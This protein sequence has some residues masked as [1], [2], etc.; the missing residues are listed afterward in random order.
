[1]NRIYTSIWNEIT[2][3]FVAAAECVRRKGKSSRSSRDGTNPKSA[4]AGRHVRRL[5]MPLALEQRFMF[6]GAAVVD[7]VH[8]I[9]D[10][11]APL[12]EAPAAVATEKHAIAF[13]DTAVKDYQALVNGLDPAVE[14]VLISD[15]DGVKQMADA[16]SG[17]TNLDAI[18][19]ISHGSEG[20]VDIGATTLNAGNLTQYADDL[21]RIGASLSDQGDLVLYGCDV[22]AGETGRQLVNDLALATGADVA[23]SGDKTGNAALGGDW[24]LEIQSG[25]IEANLPFSEAALNDF[26]SLLVGAPYNLEIESAT[27]WVAGNI[28][29]TV[30]GHTLIIDG[31]QNLGLATNGATNDYFSTAG[32]AGAPVET[33]I[34]FSFSN[35]ETFNAVSIGTIY[36]DS[37]FT[38][39]ISDNLGNSYVQSLT[40][41][42]IAPTLNWNG[43]TKLYFENNAGGVFSLQEVDN[44]NF[45]NVTAPANTAPTVTTPTAITLTDTAAADSF[46][47]T[48][49]TLSATDSDVIASYGISTGTTSG[50][51]VIGGVTYDVS[52]AGSYGTLYVK[53]GTGDYA[54]VPNASAV[55]ARTTNTSE[56]FTVTATD[57]NASPATGN[58]TLTINVT[59]ANDVPTLTTASNITGGTEDTQKQIT[60]A[61]LQTAGNEADVDGSVSAFVVKAVSSGTLLIGANAGAATP[62]DA[63]T[64]ATIDATHLAFWTPAS[65]ANGN[66]NAFTVV[67]KDD[68]GSESTTPVQVVVEIAVAND[69]PTLSGVPGSA[70][71]VTT[72][73]AAAL[74]NF[75][76]AD[77][78]GDSLTV[79]LTPTNG[80]IGGLTGWTDT[81]GVLSK[82]DTAANLNTDLAG[83]TFTATNAGAASIGVSVDDGTAAPVTGTYS[84]T[85]STPVDA[86][87]D[88]NA[89]SVA[90]A[91]VGST[92]MLDASPNATL[93]HADTSAT[94]WNGATLTA[95]R[96]GTAITTDTFAF[97]TTGASFTA[98]GG[99]L[100][101]GGQTF[102]TYTS[103][104]G[105]LTINFA[106]GGTDATNAL[107]D[108]VVQRIT[109]RNDTPA[110]NATVR[111]TLTPA[112]ASAVTADVTVTTDK[113]YVTTGTDT[114]TDNL[115]DGVSFSEALR[116]A[117]NQ[118]GTDTLVLKSTLAN[119][120]VS[121]TNVASLSGDVIVDGD[122]ASGATISNGSL[123][124]N[125][126]TLAFTNGSGDTLSV[127][128]NL[129]GTGSLAKTGAGT[130]TL[131]GTNTYSGTT[132]VTGGKVTANGSGSLG[133]SAVTLDGGAL[134]FGAT[135]SWTIA[136]NITLGAGGGTLVSS[137][138]SNGGTTT[139]SGV[140]SG[141]N[142]T[143]TSGDMANTNPQNGI[144]YLTGSNTYTGTT[145]L[146]LNN[147][148]GTAKING[149]ANLGSGNIIFTSGKLSITG[150]TT[151]DNAIQ[152]SGTNASFT[153]A[154]GTTTEIT[155]VISGNNG[156]TTSG[157]GGTLKLSGTNTYSGSTY[158]GNTLIASSDAALPDGTLLELGAGTLTLL[159]NQT[160]GALNSYA[161]LSY[162]GN[163]SVI[164]LGTY[165]FTLAGG[166]NSN[167]SGTINGSGN[168]VKNGGG[169][170]TIS[171]TTATANSGDY[172]GTTTI[173]AGALQLDGTLRGP[174]TVASGGKLSGGGAD[175]TQGKALGSVTVQSGGT[176][177]PG[178]SGGTNSTADLTTGNLTVASGGTLA[179]TVGG[180]TAGATSSG[181]D[182]VAVTGTVDITG[183]TLSVNVVGGF[184]PVAGDVFT[185]VANDSN[186]AI[187]GTFNGLAEGATV[188]VSGTPFKLSYVGGTDGNDITLTVQMVFSNVDIS[189]D[190]GITTDFITGTAAQTITA[191]LSAN[192]A[193]GMTIKGSVDGG[194]N[195]TDVTNKV[196]GMSLSWDGATLAEGVNAIKFKALNASSVNVGEISQA[197]TLDTS[198]PTTAIATYDIS[199][200]TGDA[201][202]FITKTASQTVS[203]TLGAVTVAGETVQVSAD[204]GATWAD[205]T[206]VIGENTWSLSGVTLQAG[207]NDLKVRVVDEAGNA[208]SVTTQSYTLDTT[209]PTITVSAIGISADTG[210]SA[211][212]FKTKTASQTITATLSGAPAGT[213]KVWGSVDNGANWI[214]VTSMVSGTTL[215][216]T[217][218]TLSGSST[219]K[220]KVSDEAGN[221]G[222][223]ASQA[224]V[225][226]TAAP[227]ASVTTANVGIGSNVAT[228]QSTE[229]GLIYLVPSGQTPADYAALE[230]LVTGGTATK[231]TVTTGGSN[232]PI[233]TTGLTS[234]TYKVWAVDAAGNIS[235]AS[236]NTIT[237]GTPPTTTVAT[238]ALSADTGASSTDFITNTASQTISGTL[239]AVTVA[240]EAIQVSLDNG[241]TWTNATNTT[242][243]NTW[244]LAGQTLSGS[245]ILQARVVNAGGFGSTPYTHNYTLDTTAPTTTIA[246]KS[247]SND[248]GTSS[249]DFITN[250][251]NQTISGTLSTNLAAGEIVQVSLDN[252]STWA[253][254]TATT[255]QNT[256]SLAGQTLTGS[257]TLKVRVADAAGNGGTAASQAYVLDTTAPATTVATLA[258]S[259]D[260][261]TSSTDFITSTASQ[262]ISGTLSNNLAADEIVQVSLDNGSTWTTATASTGQNTW[263]LAGQTLT[264]SDTL[265]VRVADAA[266][267][268]GSVV[269]QAYVLDT[270]VAAPTVGLTSDTGS[271]NSDK[272]TSNGALSVGGT[273][274][275]ATVQYSTDSTNWSGSFTPVNGS[276]TVYVRQTDAAGNVSNASSAYT[277]TLDTAVPSSPSVTLT[278]DTGSSN[279][280][281]VTS[282]GAL[283]VGGTEGG[284]TVQ[285]STDG[286]SWS[287]SFTPV[288]GSNT[289]YIRQA[290][291]AGNIS[292]ASSAYTFSFDSSAAAP[293][294]ALTTDTGSSN[295]DK[296]TNNGA[297]TVSGAEGGATVE[298]STDGTT[299]A[300]SFT[301]VEGSNTMY[302]RQ[303]D[304][305]GNVSTASS[306]YTFTLDTAAPSAP[307]VALT[308]D[309]GS[310]NSDKIT[311]N[312]ALTV[313]GTEPGATVE[314][315]TNGATWSSS[316]T[317]AQ[318]SNTVYVRQIDVAGNV[319][320]PSGAYAF[321]LEAAALSAPTLAL[322]TD[323]GSSSTDRI[324]GIGALT[325]SGTET[326]A[327]VE[328]STNGTTWS[329][330][331]TPV[332][333]SNTV[334]VRQTAAAGIV[335]STSSAFT[336]TLD[337]S[338][339]APAVALTTDTGTSSTDKVT[340]NS[341]LTV[342][343]TETGATVEYSTNGTTWSSGFTPAQGSNTVYV[344]QIDVA[345]N[346][347]S[348]SAAYTFTLDATATDLTG[349]VTIGG[350]SVVAQTL[351]ASNSLQDLSGET[352]TVTYVWRDGSGNVLG[353][354][355]SLTL[356]QD[357]VG[358]SIVVTATYTDAAGNQSEVSSSTF[359]PVVSPST[360]QP[361]NDSLPVT[362]P[363][364]TPVLQVPVSTTLEPIPVDSPSF[365]P[366]GSTLNT[367]PTLPVS[368]IVLTGVTPTTG[369][370]GGATGP[371]A[372]PASPSP[373]GDTPTGRTG[374]AGP[375]ESG[376]SMTTTRAP[377]SFPITVALPGS[378]VEGLVVARGV[379]DV[380]VSNTGAATVTI[381]PDT[382]AH[383]DANATVQISVQQIN[384]QPLPAWVSFDPVTGKIEMRPPRG[385]QRELAIKVIA[386]DDQGREAVTT[387]KIKVGQRDNRQQPQ[388]A[389]EIEGESKLA[390]AV[391]LQ[392][393]TLPTPVERLKLGRAGLS[394]QL[395]QASRPL[396]SSE[397][398]AALSRAAQTARRSA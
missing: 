105:V 334:Y 369:S 124:T 185:I 394:E 46:S 300:S 317:P 11:P 135:L 354:G 70:Q 95:Q 171:S 375:Q 76:V 392:R 186:D 240:G 19:V 271:S 100:H 74:D 295:S 383:S 356:T 296:I 62:F 299:W 59:G 253:T 72:G 242:G 254:A 273:E 130:I 263:S 150:N 328:Y 282:N 268:G 132:S 211:T 229:V 391:R 82:T 7:A 152:A 1:M 385:V 153:V 49:G 84:L 287:G 357:M 294:V 218:A 187:T 252:G 314:Y 239:S 18:Y 360:S 9:P 69:A 15:G 238:A 44:L 231:A 389:L 265:K 6:D 214:D 136:N 344:R 102:G 98:S 257:D 176:L 247:F 212:D 313:S 5:A 154:S 367:P 292:T 332:E 119:Q 397:R 157:S 12:P 221:D 248:T 3:T 89:D 278:S 398:L 160:V 228:S 180:T 286:T 167:F 243:Q 387:F 269:S 146:A 170:F 379:S 47:N 353:T 13:V 333:G 276:N 370:G 36:T 198:G 378:G 60:L 194:A 322:T 277:F 339:S 364:P 246:T 275:G 118:A 51:D 202:D 25:N 91:G 175:S 388:G 139:V 8:A 28:Q 161:D 200:D 373:A 306:A 365:L 122:A 323:T 42:Q 39:K 330:S 227:T 116:I 43:I 235:A 127:S 302:M 4:L 316:F 223:V 297:L 224:Y 281:K 79:T 66:L 321:T 181:Y 244:S 331:F 325:V 225:L 230:T 355:E 99:N 261:G 255:G 361:Q 88:L 289:V 61:N 141:G 169:T 371:A 149:D 216:W 308:T 270:T 31:V 315:S 205:A 35:G 384:G 48:T 336:F 97:N 33:K 245:N 310:S 362:P 71:A 45:T 320:G 210:T 352:G 350:T 155:G 14:V 188:T 52:K 143:L 106:N 393:E 162:S 260:T 301:P 363:S 53:S 128:T 138:G 382:F 349:A 233:A 159:S 115:N 226:D 20:N 40:A 377:G 80:S 65:N 78:D 267:N 38:L 166:N 201:T 178:G 258:F 288:E 114:L 305:A 329:S 22:G 376:V 368:P 335:S 359:G 37:A 104:N 109:Y 2:R 396:G 196:S 183:A 280:D 290:D 24:N 279:S 133:T 303:T 144:V 390:V 165:N 256:W 326:G 163:L 192:L 298:Y 83:A 174:I 327:T 209:A 199:A 195:W 26:S 94:N 324:T 29:Q 101:S 179:A 156:V 117:N 304:V 103:A 291:V 351:T 190:T 68:G 75:T 380:V 173:N 182:Q 81:G 203:G 319:S 21:T 236:A 338:A 145:T 307:T 23:V 311:S 232:T 30:S 112:S 168:L 148:T 111:F 345:G 285:Y 251:A 337:T 358:K 341:A 381:S 346:V 262:T 108:E 343:G 137:S 54:F 64:N 27:T 73:I 86:F 340:S 92:V 250:T 318:G 207:T 177:S 57:S 41:S 17:K 125:G 164:N 283:T 32:S 191:T 249:T 204:G 189:A 374:Q 309:T 237:L 87:V 113:I 147:G 56:T 107:A 67:A 172:S 206:N 140:I 129:T 55:N 312:G 184:I 264:G 274:G 93:T 372:P 121:A 215:T 85:A 386:R 222:T 217:G 151:I 158:V 10:T 134:G 259:A 34:T 395:R 96:A 131:S 110:G 120:S 208:G 293:T 213:D 126:N 50:S 193:T 142:L 63:S 284:A 347:S 58:A 197:Y 241:S 219:L 77:V 348:A 123:D 16:V 90:W 220:L 234:G 366:S 272:V 266:G 342:S